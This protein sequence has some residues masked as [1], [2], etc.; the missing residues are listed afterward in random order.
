M[1]DIP[2]V[3]E[4]Q[5]VFRR[6]EKKYLLTPAQHE[7]LVQRLRTEM[8][9]DPYGRHT[10]QNVYWDTDN[11]ALLRAS[12]EKP[13]YKE[14]LRVRSYGVPKAGD[15]VFIELKK[16]YKGV[17]Y[18]RRDSMTLSQA[19]AYLSGGTPPRAS[20]ILREIDQFRLQYDVGPRVFIAYERTAF[21]GRALPDLRVTFDEDI[22]WR[23]DRLD[24]SQGSRGE[25]LLP[26]GQILMEIKIP[27]AMPLWMSRALS[28]LSIF[29][30]SFSKVG[31]CYEQ[32]LAR[33][34]RF[35]SPVRREGGIRCA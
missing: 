4:Y 2:V 29:P 31:F 30:T 11:Y 7:A 34:A 10:I 26:P 6:I 18:K 35:L 15:K 8:E 16:K 22:R 1:Q 9:P 17:V 28:E 32:H 20:Q 25:I 13:V 24:L 33:E 5:S 19:N 14:K 12:L 21:L 3:A 23:A 27:E